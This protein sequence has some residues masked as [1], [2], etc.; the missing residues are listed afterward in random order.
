MPS[1]SREEKQEI[2]DDLVN[3]VAT[4]VTGPRVEEVINIAKRVLGEDVDDEQPEVPPGPGLDTEVK[5]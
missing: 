1:L 5:K 4:W 3:R 2:H